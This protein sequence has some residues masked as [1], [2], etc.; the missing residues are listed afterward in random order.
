MKIKTHSGAKKRVK[1]KGKGKKLKLTFN[2]AARRHL[3]VNK[4]KKQKSI[5]NIVAS[6]ANTKALKKMLQ[7]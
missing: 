2:K 7:K 6:A 3:L 4:S 5:R 1:V